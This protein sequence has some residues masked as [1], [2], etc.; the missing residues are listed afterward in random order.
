MESRTKKMLNQLHDF[1]FISV[2]IVCYVVGYSIFL[3]PYHI[4]TGGVAGVASI[5]YFLNGFPPQYTYLIINVFLLVLALKILGVK[6]MMNTIYAVLFMTAAIGIG[7]DIVLAHPS[8]QTVLGSQSFMACVLG[9]ALE[10]VGLAVVFLNNGSTGGTDIIA[11]CVNKYRDISLGQILLALDV[12]V[13]SSNFLVFHKLDLLLYG[14]CTMIIETF[15]LDYIM[16][17]MRQSVQFLIISQRYNAI[18]KAIN[19]TGRGVTVLDGTGWYT[20]NSQKVLVVLARRRES[21]HL[22]RIIKR[23]DSNAFVSQS[24]VVGV[25]GNGFDK[26]KGK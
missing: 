13:V 22:F 1:I 17:S 14:F 4:T 23:I 18:A 11:A 24:K 16:N 19:E 8:L 25:F 20:Q 9:A 15:M 7:Q 5:F 2:G 21:T 26:M 12:L 3:L 10:G 6:F